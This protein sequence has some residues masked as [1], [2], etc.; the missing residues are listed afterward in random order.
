MIYRGGAWDRQYWLDFLERLQTQVSHVGSQPCLCDR[1]PAKVLDTKARVRFLVGSTPVHAGSVAKSCLTLCV[2]M[3]CSL[4]GSSVYGG[5]PEKNTGV[6][7]HFLLQ[8]IFPT[9]R[10]TRISWVSCFAGGIFP[11]GPSGK[12]NPPVCCCILLLGVVCPS[13]ASLGEENLRLDL[14]W[15]PVLCAS[16]CY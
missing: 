16:S 12:R 2:P 9:Q 3:D 10:S 8:A 1:L 6:G 13:T 5:S 15:T 11:A 4:P 7:C 14:S